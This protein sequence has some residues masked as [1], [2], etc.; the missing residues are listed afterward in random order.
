MSQSQEPQNRP[1][2]YTGPDHLRT[3]L[4]AMVLNLAGDVLAL[5]QGGELRD[6]VIGGS[7][8]TM[9]V[10]TMIVMTRVQVTGVINS[11]P[12]HARA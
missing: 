10:L 5:R 2:G 3:T 7:G 6:S 12:F 4:D 9:P 8:S 1:R 11:K